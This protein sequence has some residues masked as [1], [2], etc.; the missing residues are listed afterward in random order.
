VCARLMLT[1][2][3]LAAWDITTLTVI[4]L[5]PTA[6]IYDIVG[7]ITM[8]VGTSLAPSYLLHVSVNNCFSIKKNPDCSLLA[9][10]CDLILCKLS[11]CNYYFQRYLKTILF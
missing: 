1:G 2:S 9:I 11:Q 8:V 6:F 4:C 3:E 10:I 7:G 5:N